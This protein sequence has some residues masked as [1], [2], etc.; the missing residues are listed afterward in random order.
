MRVFDA[1]RLGY[2]ERMRRRRPD[3]PS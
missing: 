3:T 2:P 1:S